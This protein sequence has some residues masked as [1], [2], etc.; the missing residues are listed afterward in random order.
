[1]RYAL[2]MVSERQGVGKTTLCHIL[3]KLVG[4]HNTSYPTESEI[5]KGTFN[6]WVAHKLLA[7][8]AEIYGG[9]SR[10]MYDH[11]KSCITDEPVDVNKKY[12]RPYQIDNRIQIAACSNFRQ[13]IHLDDDDRRWLVPRVTESLLPLGYWN[14]FYKWLQAD[15]LGIILHH[16]KELAED[17]ANV[18]GTG[19]RAPMTSMKREV[20]AES[21]SPGAQIAFTWGEIARDLKDE[22]KQPKKMVVAVY[23]VRELVAKKRQLGTEDDRLESALTIKKALVAAGL[24]EPELQPGESRK[25]YW[26]EVWSGHKVHTYIVAN[27]RISAGT[28]WEELK[29]YH[30][31]AEELWPM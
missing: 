10:K 29:Q 13:A 14:D 6:E 2:L 12:M 30:V 15:G 3:A 21:R 9:H 11:L 24:M 5:V 1:M 4:P 8:I 16:L 20:I 19:E 23:D 7:V 27:F 25:R 26:V 28:T 17:P 31:K 22:N 18:V